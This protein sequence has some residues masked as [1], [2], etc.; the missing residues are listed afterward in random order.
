M[1]PL[2]GAVNAVSITCGLTTALCLFPTLVEPLKLATQGL[3]V[4]SCCYLV[5]AKQT[6]CDK[7]ELVGYGMM[8]YVYVGFL[9]VGLTSFIPVKDG[10][11]LL[12]PAPTEVLIDSQSH[13][14]KAQETLARMRQTA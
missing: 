10:A 5:H 2:I 11:V 1:T 13:V 3:L 7:S 12:K 4:A 9:A 14:S 8:R 6:R